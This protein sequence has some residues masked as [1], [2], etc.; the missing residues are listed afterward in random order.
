MPM[1]PL[2]R[3][4]M[5]NV[6][7]KLT[8][9]L[10]N[11]LSVVCVLGMLWLAGRAEVQTQAVNPSRTAPAKSQDFILGADISWIPEQE[12]RGRRF[13]DGSVTNDIFAILKEHQFNWV[14]LRLFHNPRATNGYSAAGFCDLEHTA[15]MARRAKAAGMH[16]LLDLHYGDT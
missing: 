11:F 9:P 14:R 2:T 4:M 6:P 12:A 13:F 10:A 3:T 8:G 16:F 15:Q 5:Q 1:R 7:A